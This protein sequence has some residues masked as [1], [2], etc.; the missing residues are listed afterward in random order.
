[1]P[2]LADEGGDVVV[3]E[4]GA[5]FESHR[6]FGLIWRAFYAQ[7]PVGFTAC[8]ELPLGGVRTAAQSLSRAERRSAGWVTDGA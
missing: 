6:L 3:A 5:D 1:M 2:P 7:V 4:S 8:T